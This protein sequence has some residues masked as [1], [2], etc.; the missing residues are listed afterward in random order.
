VLEKTGCACQAELMSLLA[1][2]ILDRSA[3]EN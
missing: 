2:V 3:A 1:N